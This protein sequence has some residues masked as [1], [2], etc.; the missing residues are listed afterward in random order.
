MSHLWGSGSGWAKS[1]Q[2]HPED[3]LEEL[4]RKRKVIQWQTVVPVCQP[5]PEVPGRALA[6]PPSSNLA[7]AKLPFHLSCDVRSWEQAVFWILESK[8]TAHSWEKPLGVS[9]PSQAGTEAPLPQGYRSCQDS[10]VPLASAEET[11]RGTSSPWS[12]QS[13]DSLLCAEQVEKWNPQGSPHFCEETHSSSFSG[14]L[15]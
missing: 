10:M 14:T 15:L 8:K 13:W 4:E 12:P 11:Q 7:L 3:I 1:G 2:S 9:S 5:L 6:A